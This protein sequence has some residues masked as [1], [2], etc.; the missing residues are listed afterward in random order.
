MEDLVLLSR[1]SQPNGPP[2][3]PGYSP[4]AAERNWESLTFHMGTVI[5]HELGHL[6]MAYL[7][8]PFGP[9][10]HRP[11][12]PLQMTPPFLQ[13]TYP[14]EGESGY[15]LDMLLYGGT[16]GP[17]E[18]EN[19]PLG[20]HQGGEMWHLDKDMLIG[21][22]RLD[23][24]WIRRMLNLDF[25][26]RKYYSASMRE[27]S[28]APIVLT[29]SRIELEPAGSV[30]NDL[31]GRDEMSRA[32]LNRLPGSGAPNF[33]NYAELT[34]QQSSDLL[35]VV[36]GSGFPIRDIRVVLPLNPYTFVPVGG[37][38]PMTLVQQQ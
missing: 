37:Q 36:H 22:R 14:I 5:A 12:T 15:W 1:A 6:W 33:P 28:N 7:V 21:F 11:Q 16:I 30:Y 31:L 27:I 32:R 34:V 26:E 20:T 8:M 2:I 4:L 24:D 35:D 38:P 3:V 25:E 29:F 9:T 23:D 19:H 13:G 10:G 18:V 17:Y